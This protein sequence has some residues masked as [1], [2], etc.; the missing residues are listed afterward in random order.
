MPFGNLIYRYETMAQIIMNVMNAHVSSLCLST[1]LYFC[2]SLIAVSYMMFSNAL[3]AITA[4]NTPTVK[5]V[6]AITVVPERRIPCRPLLLLSWCPKHVLDW[7]TSDRPCSPIPSL[8]LY[9]ACWCLISCTSG[10]CLTIRFLDLC[11]SSW[12]F[13]PLFCFILS[14]HGVK[15]YCYINIGAMRHGVGIDPLSLHDP[16]VATYLILCD[17]NTPRPGMLPFIFPVQKNLQLPVQ[18]SMGFLTRPV[19]ADQSHDHTGHNKES[20]DY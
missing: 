14:D 4:M 1:R 10:V 12:E 7:R 18:V 16:I 17:Y 9:V 15:N 5:T 11:I 13:V 2:V 3:K 8:L 19:T 20:N 6:L